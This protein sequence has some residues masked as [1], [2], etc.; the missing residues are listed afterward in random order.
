METNSN[1]RIEYS[2]DNTSESVIY[3]LM[4]IEEDVYAE[5]DRGQYEHI[6]KRFDKNKEM[7][8]L[9]YDNDK[10][11]GY[12]CYFP[13]SQ[14]LHD[15]II[16]VK[17]FYDDNIKA[18][19]VISFGK[20][21]YIYL[22]SI[23]LFKK[24]HGKGLGKKMMDAFFCKLREKNKENKHIIDIFASVISNAGEKIAREYGFE[25]FKDV[26][27]EKGYKLMYLDGS[28]I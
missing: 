21:N 28:N 22:I 3:D 12:L 23:A 20:E 14:E 2:S 17:K 11:I 7:F 13:I 18:K 27:N 24:Y 9:L 1:Y 4:R 15:N 8:V 26:S 25:L 5:K 19:D 10:I 6:K 16:G